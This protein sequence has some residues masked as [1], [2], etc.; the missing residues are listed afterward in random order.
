MA[1]FSKV[2]SSILNWCH[3]FATFKVNLFFSRC[4]KDDH[5]FNMFLIKKNLCLHLSPVSGKK[6]W[7]M[8]QSKIA[9]MLPLPRKRLGKYAEHLSIWADRNLIKLL[10]GNA[11]SFTWAGIALG[12]GTHWDKNESWQLGKQLGKDGQ[13]APGLHFAEQCQYAEGGEP[14]PLL[15]GTSFW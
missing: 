4:R 12:T 15:L 9:V 3:N 6:R 5:T 11:K 13:Q 14:Y 10:K 7:Q 2:I 8:K 1:L